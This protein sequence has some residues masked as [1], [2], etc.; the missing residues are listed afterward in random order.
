MNRNLT[1]SRPLFC[2]LT[3][4]VLALANFLPILAPRAL[5]SVEAEGVPSLLVPEGGIRPG[6]EN[7]IT[8]FLPE[9]GSYTI[10]LRGDALFEADMTLQDSEAPAGL[11]TLTYDG[12]V[13]GT[14][15]DAGEYVQ[16]LHQGDLAAEFP[17]RVTLPAPD[18]LDLAVPQHALS[19]S[20]PWE[21][22]Y[23]ATCPGTLQVQI[24][25]NGATVNTIREEISAGEGTFS[26]DAEG[27]PGGLYTLLV[28]LED[29]SGLTSDARRVM[30]DVARDT[31]IPLQTTVFTPTYGSPYQ[32]E[33]F[34][35]WTMPMDITDEE[36][37]WKAITEPV[38]VLDTG[39]KNAQKTQITI[40]SEPSLDAPGVGVVTCISQAVHVLETLDNGW[41]KIEC[42]SSSFFDSKVKA[43][44]MLVQGYVETK[45]L[46]TTVPSQKIGMVIDKLTQR[47]Y[48]FRDGHLYDTLMVSTGLANARQPYN[49]TRSG[50]FLLLLP[51]VGEF[52]SDDLY[53]SMAIRFNSGDMLH[54]VPHLIN[55]DGTYNYGKTEAALGERASHGCIRVQRHK[56][57]LGTNM[58]WIWNHKE[59]N[60]KLLIWED[61]Q[62]RQ[63]S[64]PSDDTTVY[65]NPKN[66]KSYHASETC[67]SAT[68][69]TF[70]PFTYGELEDEP[71]ASL[72]RCDYCNPPLRKGEIDSINLLHAPGGDHDPI[73]TE[74]REALK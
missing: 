31:D 21:L 28:S 73:L 51:A 44:N 20:S 67:Y 36:A 17:V 65:Y 23:Y 45:Y 27:M 5:T 14:P 68:G 56:T 69:K 47:L 6:T 9:D 11:Y 54:E 43:W 3:C 60:M 71:Y 4:L 2:C 35:Y 18:L 58:K 50:E 53:C 30:V 57:S 37:I 7:E 32:D 25:R 24:T 63:I 34:S 8:F 59:K 49:E 52:R 12:L 48:L 70:T 22:G 16:S 62:G 10:T 38:T 64:Y 66:G 13:Q 46:K 61:W 42:Y 19:E 26:W 55:W 74:A 15:L 1:H 40:R 72:T 29:E 39:K 41:T 33:E